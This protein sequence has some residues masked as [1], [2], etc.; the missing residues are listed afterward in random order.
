MCFVSVAPDL[1]AWV[2]G[3]SYIC[4]EQWHLIRLCEI[5][6]KDLISVFAE[7]EHLLIMSGKKHILRTVR[8]CVASVVVSA[9][10]LL[11]FD[12]GGIFDR[13]LSWL[14]KL[15]FW[16]A[17]L[18]LNVASMML[19]FVLTMLFGRVY[20]SFLCPLGICQDAVY[21]IRSSLKGKKHRNRQHYRKAHTTLR[22]AILA[23]FIVTAALGHGAIAYLIEPYSIFGR[24]LSLATTKALIPGLI[25]AATLLTICIWAWY[26]G[27]SWCNTICPVGTILGVFSKRSLFKP[28]I[29]HDSCVSCGL[30]EKNCRASAI[31]VKNGKIDYS[32][33]VACFDCLSVCNKGS[34]SYRFTMGKDAAYLS[35]GNKARKTAA[36]GNQIHRAADH[37]YAAAQGNKQEIVAQGMSRKAFLG[38]AALIAGSAILKAQEG[39]G[40]LGPLA[41]RRVPERKVPVVPPGAWSLRHFDAHCVA[42]Q[43]CVNAC[44]NSVLTPDLSPGRFMLPKMDFEK[45]WCRVECNACSRVC[46]ASAIVK[47]DVEHKSSVSI[48]YAV[49]NPDT[50]VVNTDGVECGNCARH[51]PAGAI[52]MVKDAYTGHRLPVVNAERCIGC[53]RCEYVC[54]SRPVSAIH[55]EGR[56]QHIE[57]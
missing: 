27:R 33:C 13:Y 8:V 40:V 4:K 47:I 51:C 6:I 30:C 29:D 45:S 50:C 48:G 23:A 39:H 2:G 17:V 19:I 46:P 1:F 26:S 18:A 41:E 35:G 52:S 43:L 7:T 12:F 38:S 36:Q 42:C 54:P 10:I 3:F 15:Q 14:P 34:M 25:S 55:V 11:F 44:P 9:F 56:H 49:F 5:H 57:I 28:V 53:G 22:L 21:G 32:K 24:T 16:P 37:G 31:D 20:C